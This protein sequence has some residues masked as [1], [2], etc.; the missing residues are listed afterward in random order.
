MSDSDSFFREVTEEVERDRMNRRLKKYGPYIAAVVLVIV[1]AAAA[2][3]WK[4]DQDRR[5][6]ED[7]GLLL[8]SADPGAAVE[9]SGELSA[10]AIMLAKM[11]A[12]DAAAAAGDTPGAVD[13]FSKIAETPG[14]EPAFA[15]LAALR[16][17]RLRALD[18]PP[19]EVIALLGPLTQD[20]RPYRLLALELRAALLLNAGKTDEAQAD[21]RVILDDP[22]RTGNLDAR[23]EQLLLSSGGQRGE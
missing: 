17:L 2:W 6:A 9:S 22:D 7:R 11:R 15:D 14:A 19:E 21:M 3:N 1:A 4:K 5:S 13:L 23:V 18:Q 16:A 10:G 8:L 20:G 12:A